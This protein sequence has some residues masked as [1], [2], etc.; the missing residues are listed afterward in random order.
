MAALREFGAHCCKASCAGNGY[1]IGKHDNV[2]AVR[3]K[4]LARGLIAEPARNKALP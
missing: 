3:S 4:P 1:S 2:A